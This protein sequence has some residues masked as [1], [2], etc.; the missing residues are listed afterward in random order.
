VEITNLSNQE[1]YSLFQQQL[2]EQKKKNE[3]RFSELEKNF[4][5]RYSQL[6]KK[7]EIN[8]EQLKENK[9]RFS[10]LKKI[11]LNMKEKER[12][13]EKKFSELKSEIQSLKGMISTIQIRKL[14]KNFLNIFKSDLSEEEKEIIKKDESKKGEETLKSLKRKYP[15]YIDTENFKTVYEIV[16]KSGEALNKGNELEK[17]IFLKKMGI[18]DDTFDKCFKFIQNNVEKK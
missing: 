2:T 14:A 7:I 12:E 9:G 3:I 15:L 8:S 18:S 10:E 17:D 6:K 13:N 16:E 5:I 1:L 4:E 11:S